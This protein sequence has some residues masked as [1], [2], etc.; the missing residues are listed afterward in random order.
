M[1]KTPAWENPHV[2]QINRLPR[3]ATT[4]P[5]KRLRISPDTLLYDID[6]HR[7]S[8]NG[9]W[10]F[11]WV[12]SPDQL[13]DGFQK[14]DFDDSAWDT[15]PVPAHWEIHGYGTPIYRNIGLPFHLDPPRVTAE[16]PREWSTYRERNPV[17]TYRRTFQLPEDWS[18]REVFGYFGGVSAAFD[19][20]INGEHVGYSQDSML[21][22]EFRLSPFLQPGDNL[23][24]VAVYRYC[25]GSYL[26]D[27]DFWYLSGIF[28]DVFLYAQAPTF[29]R[30]VTATGDWNAAT[31]E[32]ALEIGAEIEHL[33]SQV[34]QNGS[35]EVS[36]FAE[37]DPPESDNFITKQVLPVDCLGHQDHHVDTRFNELKVE[38]WSAETPNLYAIRLLLRDAKNEIIDIRHVRVGFRRVELKERQLFL[39]G[40]SIK[41]KG[42]NRHEHNLHSGRV[43][44]LSQMWQDAKM[45]KAANFN[46]VRT[47]HYPHDPRWYEICDQI[48]LYVMDEA[49]VE[50]HAL[51]YH[52]RV[53]PGDQ[54]QWKAQ[55]IERVVGMVKRD[56]NSPSIISW[57]LGNEAGYGETF[58]AMAQA[59]R[60]LDST[61]FI[62]YA[63]MN[64]AADVDSQTYP[65]QHWLLQYVQG[66]AVRK[67]EEGKP[68]NIEQ[69]GPQPTEKP[70]VMN[71]YAY[72][73]GNSC[74]GFARYWEILENHPMLIGGF[75]W[76]WCEH[77]LAKAQ[78][79]GSI[80]PG[81]GG[82][83]GDFPHDGNVCINGVV[84]ADRTPNP[85]LVEVT[86]VQKPFHAALTP[87]RTSIR[88]RNRF[89]F[90]DLSAFVIRLTYQV[91]GQEIKTREHTINTPP[92]KTSDLP[93]ESFPPQEFLHQQSILVSLV[94]CR[95]SRLAEA[96]H[97]V[98]TEFILWQEQALRLPPPSR[99]IGQIEAG[100]CVLIGA[101]GRYGI[102]Q[103]S[104]LLT[105]WHP[106]TAGEMKENILAVP[107]RP[108]FTRMPTQ[109]ERR[110]GSYEARKKW[111]EVEDNLRLVSLDFDQG[112]SELKAL[113]QTP[114][115]E[116]QI[117]L[118]YQLD[119]EGG[120]AIHTQLCVPDDV[121]P[122]ARIGWST[123]LQQTIENVTWFGR[124]PG[125]NYLDRQSGSHP[126]RY[127]LPIDQ[128]FFP[129]TVAQE[130]GLRSDVRLLELIGPQSERLQFG[131]DKPFCF[132]A[133]P[134]NE[135][136]LLADRHHEEI[137]RDD[138]L[139]LF[140]DHE[141]IGVGGIDGWMTPVPAEDQ[142]QPG[143]RKF[144]LTLRAE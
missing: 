11:A 33:S 28:R 68:S 126:G 9:Q 124:G 118:T 117:R 85:S 8:L 77:G 89:D 80:L 138:L 12:P 36:I 88:V 60:E 112:N 114:D 16:P 30:D 102:D 140:L 137:I 17:G 100:Q 40:V 65:S 121:E 2:T 136:E 69:H 92:G 26:E 107:L 13:S 74:G 131:A 32:G 10:A 1:S 122:P 4:W 48:G 99:K 96:G 87:D 72:A 98:G 106:V 86:Q 66:K 132:N 19:L 14:T 31:G 115:H 139:T 7:I 128:L 53:L 44:P 27:Q 97:V 110:W 35:I 108:R 25:D 67:S 20:W 24:V 21:P 130:S 55:A 123:R 34:F 70:F 5:A 143:P 61:R 94:R 104:G 46:A 41:L 105:S 29:I 54:P 42:V 76:Q 119:V 39:N 52:R 63:D 133:F 57:S 38:P 135:S 113:L 49:N 82:D 78:P 62:H 22:A 71:E 116:F 93:L 125:E 111:L 83:F 18:E 103:V 127:A 73:A 101:Q 23:I 142:I 120:L 81:Y 58:P 56:R 64:L 84:K 141:H 51:S 90:V 75:Q 50:C 144:C 37:N 6:D 3:R 45:I 129:Y 15:L 109:N 95:S 134:F 59:V 79:D 91:D 47:S 43:I